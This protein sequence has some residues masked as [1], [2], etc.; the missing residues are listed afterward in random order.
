[1][2]QIGQEPTSLNKVGMRSEVLGCVC[3]LVGFKWSGKE[4]PMSDPTKRS[5]VLKRGS[6]LTLISVYKVPNHC[7]MIMTADSI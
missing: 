3:A 5:C 1:M 2:V 7:L 4:L 6:M